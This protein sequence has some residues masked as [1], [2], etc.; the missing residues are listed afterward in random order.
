MS[1]LSVKKTKNHFYML[2]RKMP[3]FQSI[4]SHKNV[5][6]SRTTRLPGLNFF[7]LKAEGYIYNWKGNLGQATSLF[8]SYWATKSKIG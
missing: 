5:Y 8:H 4:H 1:K 6:I 7:P 3:G 2:Y